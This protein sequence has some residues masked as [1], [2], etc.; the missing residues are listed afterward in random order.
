M[1]TY[2]QSGAFDYQSSAANSPVYGKHDYYSYRL[3]DGFV[4]NHREIVDLLETN[5][6][7]PS[8]ELAKKWL[9]MRQK[10][11][12]A[13][14]EVVAALVKGR[15]DSETLEWLGLWLEGKDWDVLLTISHI[16]NVD[17][18]DWL[19]QFVSEHPNHRQAG[20]LWANLLMTYKY[21]TLIRA[22]TQWFT[23]HTVTNEA[24]RVAD[25]LLPL[26]KDKYVHEQAIVLLRQ[27]KDEYLAARLIECAG[28]DAT[29]ELGCHIMNSI[30]P[31]RGEIIARSLLENN[32]KNN[33]S[34]VE[35]WLR[36][37]WH[38]KNI[39]YFLQDLACV[40]PLTVAPL[41]FKWIEEN[42]RS[43][44]ISRIFS[45]AFALARSQ[46]LV[47]VLWGWMRTQLSERYAPD[48]IAQLFQHFGELTTP[49]EAVVAADNWLSQSQNLEHAKYSSI[50]LGVLGIE[51]TPTRVESA[52]QWLA[53][54]PKSARGNMLMNLRR[55]AP[56]YFTNEAIAWADQYPSRV[57]SGVIKYEILQD[58]AQPQQGMIQ[59]VKAS[60]SDN[61]LWTP[62]MCALI[63]AGDV[64]SIRK[65]K[66]LLPRRMVE[67]R[68]S[69]PVRCQQAPILVALLAAVPED[70][71]VIKFAEDWLA[72]EDSV[73]EEHLNQVSEEYVKAIERRRSCGR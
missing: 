37:H 17:V 39:G 33:W 50:L 71:F 48:M 57:E 60:L 15:H 3:S 58:T 8:V 11:T 44:D 34:I 45:T 1:E 73:C 12:S 61:P 7:D 14:R 16:M 64:E 49:P 26:T 54:Q 65:A 35:C 38:D 6:S 53:T 22:A 18:H 23:A 62:M 59:Q 55:R 9:S 32:P 28:D 47:E 66:D 30:E 70:K 68:H 42:P 56:Q 25:Q 31:S 63:R 69:E 2:D 46:E 51:N 52:R 29:I 41:A 24:V 36:E 5:P 67:L 72:S 27:F 21:K 19:I 43:P 4:V 13:A 20:E 10:S 40:A